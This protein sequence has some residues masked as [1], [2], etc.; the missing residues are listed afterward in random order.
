MQ[1]YG[2]IIIGA[3]PAGLM[4]GRVL[5]KEDINFLIIDSKKEIGKPLR[6]GE[7]IRKDGFL[8]LFKNMNYDFIENTIKEHIF[9]YDNLKKNVNINCIKID[10]PKFEKWLAEPI[11]DKV[12]L[13]VECIDF[14][15]F[16]NYV[17][18]ITNKGNYITDLI[19]LCCGPNFK[20]QKKFGLIKKKVK[21]IPCYG[22]IYNG[23]FNKDKFDYYYNDRYV[24]YF[25]I[26]PNNMGKANIGF[27]AYNLK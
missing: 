27:G 17:K 23:K 19:I 24:G 21:V 10:R 7:A 11:K 1:K 6:C 2:V 5:S 4:A 16:D 20:F 22:G 8:K 13:K 26:F 3:G 25:W 15:I 18:V 9:H 14:E 12:K